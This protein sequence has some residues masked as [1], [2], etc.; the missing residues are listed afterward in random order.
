MCLGETICWVFRFDRRKACQLREDRDMKEH[1]IRA[2]HL[3]VAISTLTGQGGGGGCVRQE[4][5]AKDLKT[6]TQK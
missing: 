6:V 2:G 4:K 3:N 5:C 1:R